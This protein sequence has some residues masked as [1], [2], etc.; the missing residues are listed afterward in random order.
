MNDKYTN[1]QLLLV[2]QFVVI[3]ILVNCHCCA[4]IMSWRFDASST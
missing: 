2:C 3:V 4:K 1:K